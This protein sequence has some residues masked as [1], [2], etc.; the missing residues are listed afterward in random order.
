M[1]VYRNHVGGDLTEEQS[2]L[3]RDTAFQNLHMNQ[4]AGHV[5]L[6]PNRAH[7]GKGCSIALKMADGTIRV[8]WVKGSYYVSIFDNKDRNQLEI[9]FDHESNF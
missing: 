8:I 1:K 3:L 9:D 2:R 6:E 5:I 4:E 7:K